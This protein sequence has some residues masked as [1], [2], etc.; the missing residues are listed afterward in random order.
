MKLRSKRK[1]E[2]AKRDTEG[3]DNI[4]LR[5]RSGNFSAGCGQHQQQQ[6]VSPS[7]LTTN[8]SFSRLHSHE[9]ASKGF[10]R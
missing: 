4:S 3:D 6:M 5:P 10:D 7:H 1:E 2:G 9:D 8:N